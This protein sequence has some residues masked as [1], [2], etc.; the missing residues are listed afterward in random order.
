MV[1][2]VILEMVEC[3]KYAYVIKAKLPFEIRLK[4]K[5]ETT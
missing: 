5:S 1:K 2:E 4:T 3:N